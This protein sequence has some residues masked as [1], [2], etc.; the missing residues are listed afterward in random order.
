MQVCNN[1]SR[2]Y[3]ER[4]RDY[5][6]FFVNGISKFGGDSPLAIFSYIIQELLESLSTRLWILKSEKAGI[7]EFDG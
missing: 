3:V 6:F 4:N 2:E 5:T 1:K 7:D